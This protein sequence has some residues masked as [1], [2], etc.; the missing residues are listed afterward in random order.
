MAYEIVNVA[1]AQS[2]SAD[3]TSA[4]IDARYYQHVTIQ[5][6]W[7]G[8]PTGNFTI[9]VS[10]DEGPIPT[11]WVTVASSTQAAGGAA[12]SKNYEPSGGYAWYRVF[13]DSSSSTGTLTANA[14]LKGFY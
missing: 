4:T 13:Y 11:N 6:I 12:G 7:T 10:N 9:E 8:T 1:S 14:C 5:L 2:L 3:F